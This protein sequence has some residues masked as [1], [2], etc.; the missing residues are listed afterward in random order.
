MGPFVVGDGSRPGA[1]AASPL[2]TL[3]V[4][5]MLAEFMKPSTFIGGCIF[6]AGLLAD[7]A[8][9]DDEV[10]AVIVIISQDAGT[11]DDTDEL[12]GVAQEV[13]GASWSVQPITPAAGAGTRGSARELQRLRERYLEADFLG[14][15]ATLQQPALRHERL[16]EAGEASDAGWVGTLGAACAYGAGDEDLAQRLL[17]P[18]FSAEIDLAGALRITTPDF[19]DLA[20]RVR[21]QTQHESRVTL[22]VTTSPDTASVTLDGFRACDARPCRFDVF[23]GEHYITA[24]ALGHQDRTI[25]QVVSEARTTQLSLDRASAEETRTQLAAALVQGTP[26]DAPEWME[27]ASHAYASRV[28]VSLYQASDQAVAALYDR[29]LSRVVARASMNGSD[30]RQLALR[31]VVEE[32]QGIVEPTSVFEQPLFW[33]GA[34]AALAATVAVVLIVLTPQD[35]THALV[36]SN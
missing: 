10:P 24:S 26:P 29:G 19:Q 30:G 35:P 6:C 23:P 15:L 25:R 12:R 34:G 22:T 27:S 8:H 21:Q 9:A 13:G 2:H 36:F 33:V 1:C 31:S 14:C 11:G 20:E 28:A 16:L 7:T 32:W 17:T 5:D 4:P 18:L 3:G